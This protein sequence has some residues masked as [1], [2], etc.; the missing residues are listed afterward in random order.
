LEKKEAT[1]AK[2]KTLTKEQAQKLEEKER[3]EAI[4]QQRKKQ[5]KVLKK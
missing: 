2:P 4:K 3:K 1:T 5:V